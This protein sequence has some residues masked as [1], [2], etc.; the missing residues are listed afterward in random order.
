LNL[1]HL[2]IL[3]F[4]SKP[5]DLELITQLE[6]QIGEEIPRLEVERDIAEVF[7]EIQAELTPI[8]F[9]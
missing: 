2:L 1:L 4:K 5:T 7:R 8:N 6:K 9:I 3:I